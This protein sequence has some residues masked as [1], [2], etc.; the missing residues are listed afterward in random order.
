M[1]M[2]AAWRIWTKILL[3]A[4]LLIGCNTLA[5]ALAAASAQAMSGEMGSCH[6]SDRKGGQTMTVCKAACLAVPHI[7]ADIRPL[8]V[9]RA[10]LQPTPLRTLVMRTSPPDTPPPRG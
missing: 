8:I 4:G 3:V 7:A 1:P 2:V 6:D 10:P 5:P 9:D